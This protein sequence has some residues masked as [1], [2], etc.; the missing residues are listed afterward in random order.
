M[1]EYMTGMGAQAVTNM[2]ELGP[3]VPDIPPQPGEIIN[4]QEQLRPLPPELKVFADELKAEKGPFVYFGKDSPSGMEFTQWLMVY[5][6]QY[7]E[8]LMKIMA[9]KMA[10]DVFAAQGESLPDWMDGDALRYKQELYDLYVASMDRVKALMSVGVTNVAAADAQPFM[11][12]WSEADRA[13]FAAFI[14][15][16][17]PTDPNAQ[18]PVPAELFAFAKSTNWKGVPTS[19]MLGLDHPLWAGIKDN[20][21]MI[22]LGSA[23]GVFAARYWMKKKAQEEAA[24]FEFGETVMDMPRSNKTPCKNCW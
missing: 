15:Q 22:L 6:P 3:G 19:A 14:V 18:I 12:W 17:P 23:G 10:K 4:G 5:D 11:Q 1:Y 8:W 20:W 2:V 13:G 9:L 7:M 16:N 24:S 21:F